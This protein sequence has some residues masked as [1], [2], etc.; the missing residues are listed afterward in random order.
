MET[1]KEFLDKYSKLYDMN[2]MM[3]WYNDFIVKMKEVKN[4]QN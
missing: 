4:E 3:D 2:S 1:I